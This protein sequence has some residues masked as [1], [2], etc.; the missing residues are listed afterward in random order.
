MNMF[1][2]VIWLVDGSSLTG[3]P[4]FLPSIFLLS[5]LNMFNNVNRNKREREKRIYSAVFPC[6]RLCEL[7]LVV[8]KLYKL[9]I[10]FGY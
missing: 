7:T 9:N 3:C 5:H 2:Y 6:L 4:F 10:D 1:S 8:V